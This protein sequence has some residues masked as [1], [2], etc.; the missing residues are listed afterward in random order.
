MPTVPTYNG[1]GVAPSSA[2]G[3]GF[4]APQAANAA[5]QQLQQMGDATV[6]A[7]AVGAN[8][9]SDIEMMA[10]Q[11]RADDS[12][13]QLVQFKQKQTYDPQ[14]G[15]LS[16][17]GSAAL[18]ADPLGRSL[19]QRY[20]EEMQDKINELSGKLGNDVQRRLFLERANQ[21][22][23]QFNGE[24]EGHVLQEY[25]S[26]GLQTQQGT[27]KLAMDAAKLAWKDQKAIDQNV[28]SAQAAVWKAGQISGEPGNLTEAKI[29][30]TTSAI[31]S[32]V[33]DAAL[34]SDNPA[35][36]LEY[37]ERN[38]AQMTADDLLKVR[39]VVNKDAYQRVADSI[40]TNV[41]TAARTN[42]TPTDLGRMVNITMKSESGG[43]ER[44]AAG[45]LITSSKGAQGAMQVM[46][47][48]AIAP[49]FGVTPAKDDSD[50]ER[51]RVG[52]DYLQAL[53]KN[54]AGDPA[55][56][57]AAYN[58]GPANVDTAI[59]EHGANWLS[60]APKETQDYV[61][62]NLAALGS[63]AGAR[64]P[65]LLEVHDQVRAQVEAKFGATP[66]AGVLKLALAS[67]TQQFEDLSKAI[68]ADEDQR[69]SVAMQGLMQNGGRFSSLP[70]AVRSQI[71]ADK[72]DNVLSFAQK[73]AKGDD[74][75]NPAVY[76]RLSDPTVLRRL[77]DDEFFHL[78]GELSESDFKH[79]S[80]QRAAAQDKATNKVEEINMSAMNT[81]LRDR[82]QSLGIDPTPKDGS[83][84]AARVGA[85]KKFVTDSML[86]QQKVTG[87]Q[88]TDAEV[89]KH[90]DGLFAKSVSFRT[91]FLGF[92]TGNSSQRL[93]TMQASD[94]PGGTRDALVADFKRAG[95]DKPTDADLLGA[96]FRLKQLPPQPAPFRQSSQAKA[97]KIT[98]AKGQ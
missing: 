87:K 57:W 58:W 78:R 72:V 21:L 3:G 4:A 23:T 14:D 83:D 34:Q 56:A 84:E 67:A 69:V 71:P 89:E 5:P 61:T 48:T 92:E 65:T 75:T 1:A 16:K 76:Q 36:A 30:E 88:M 17:K 54:Y 22:A 91:S 81:A 43:R 12:W 38:K 59:K 10:N 90:I 94:I 39:A 9:V 28:Q 85:I 24:V 29:K 40:A 55:K 42:A 53:V 6:R 31:H 98:I 73:V 18:D 46:P 66:P 37:L 60:F 86:A 97:G 95:I 62:K 45:N 19:P 51:T 68:K 2:P 26:F 8:V 80:A 93:L 32:N 50:T 64:K 96:Y 79:F 52:R 44:D 35:Y 74:I 63:G 82:F 15:L 13:N 47:G 49:G 70:Y 27:V 11:V 7:N 33:I 41:V 25:R 77:S 20:G